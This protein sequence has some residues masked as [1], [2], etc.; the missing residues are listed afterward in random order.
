MQKEKHNNIFKTLLNNDLNQCE[1]ADENQP[2]H[3]FLTQTSKKVNTARVEEL[4]RLLKQQATVEKAII[5]ASNELRDLHDETYAAFKV[6]IEGRLKDCASEK[7]K[8]R[9]LIKETTTSVESTS[10]Q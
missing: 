4:A 6:V 3:H 8:V 9:S 1:T 7:K 2:P 5:S 10:K